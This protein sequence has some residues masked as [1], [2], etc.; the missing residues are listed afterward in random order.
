MT[1][2][3]NELELEAK[4]AEAILKDFCFTKTH[5]RE[6][7]KMKPAADAKPVKTFKKQRV[8]NEEFLGPQGLYG[9]K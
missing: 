3:E 7:Y 2:T 8:I 6:E 1:T 4:R 9:D 5:I